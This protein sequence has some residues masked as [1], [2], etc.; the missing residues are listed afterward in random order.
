MPPKYT[1]LALLLRKFL[2]QRG[3]ADARFTAQQ[4]D[5]T[6]VPDGGTKPFRQF[7]ETL[8]T[9]EE[10]HRLRTREHVEQRRLPSF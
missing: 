10:F 3:L 7:G 4:R 6:A 5:T 8:F 1:R 9:L 2:Q